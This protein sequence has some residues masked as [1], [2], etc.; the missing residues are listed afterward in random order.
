[1]SIPADPNHAEA[2]SGGAELAVAITPTD[3][4][5]TLSSGRSYAIVHVPHAGALEPSAVRRIQHL[6][7][8]GAATA[9]ALGVRV[10][11]PGETFSARMRIAVTR[12]KPS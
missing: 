7:A 6:L 3:G 1:M 5:V 4:R 9:D 11:Q 12:R 10:L 2:S 8:Q